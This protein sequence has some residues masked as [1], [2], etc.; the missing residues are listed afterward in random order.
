[1]S[2]AGDTMN[3]TRSQ[4]LRAYAPGALFAFEGGGAACRAR[5]TGDNPEHSLHDLPRIGRQQIASMIQE[6]LMNWVRR[7][8]E[9]SGDPS[10]DPPT[11]AS[12][13]MTGDIL[14]HGRP[15]IGLHN[16]R[17]QSPETVGY[18]P[19]PL[20][21]RCARCG[22][23]REGQSAETLASDMAGFSRACPN[24]RE[25]CADNWRQLD[26]VMAHPSGNV[27][28][29]SPDR[30]DLAPDGRVFRRKAS[31]PN[32][33]K[34]E[35]RWTG[36]G[37][38][39]LSNIG[40][41]CVGCGTPV[42]MIENDPDVLEVLGHAILREKKGQV[43]EM[44]MEAISFRANA[45]FL[46]VG[47]RIL[48]FRE[49][50]VMG[51]LQDGHQAELATLLGERLGIKSTGVLSDARKRELAERSGRLK[52]W[53]GILGQWQM[54]RDTQRMNP[55][56]SYLAA[57]MEGVTQSEAKF[58]S[59]VFAKHVSVSTLTQTLID[60][61][62]AFP[63]RFDP[64]RMVLE[65]AAFVTEKLDTT[66][67]PDG[68]YRSV[69]VTLLDPFTA[70][71]GVTGSDL[72]SL[73]AKSQEWLDLLGIQEMR[74][75]R[76]VRVADFTFGYTRTT[77]DPT[78]KR[79][80]KSGPVIPVR[81]NMFE[82]VPVGSAV[83]GQATRW[84]YPVLTVVSSN[85][86][87]YF[88]LKPK[89]VLAWIKANELE[90]P[91]PEPGMGLGARLLAQAV[92]VQ[93]GKDLP[94]RFDP[95]LD[96]FRREG[97]TPPLAYPFVYTLLHTIAH[98]VIQHAS[99]LSGLEMGAFAEHLFVPDLAVLVYRSGTTMDLGNLSSMWR[100]RGSVALG[101]EFLVRMAAP[102]ALRCGSEGSCTPRGGA[103]PDC[104]MIPETSCI[105]RNELL[106][107]SVLLGRGIP[108]WAKWPDSR[109]EMT[110]FYDVV[111]QQRR[112]GS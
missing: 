49:D 3:R 56:A 112:S 65:H 11:P 28:S 15:R 83:A 108:R 20:S 34:Q 77:S 101:N 18:E 31:C 63:N 43:A 79:R 103:C 97:E 82:P 16:L 41:A 22:L 81:L 57:A 44:R 104:V 96:E 75:V 9:N 2:G 23:H 85:E 4:M 17:F 48:L 36:I 64:V 24:G 37:T 29:P 6:H 106:S 74:I 58:H 45:A 110:G 60:G 98:Q 52:E 102:A 40:F 66:P 5:S 1:M 94:G 13:C 92:A 54:I 25:N 93:T 55:D 90:L 87:I 67:L 71:D 38:G 95:F 84:Q 70:P 39:V 30:N 35:F 51:L 10:R 42:E 33:D 27:V 8:S 7:A 111:D 53:E 12:L 73:H 100:D 59:E 46:P 88:R 61:R 14:E 68:R 80:S 76:D 69:P 72:D 32:C 21:F 78:R 99:A 19:F 47:D 86:G 91:E 107:R 109:A 26:F 50:G 62:E 89:L 105:A